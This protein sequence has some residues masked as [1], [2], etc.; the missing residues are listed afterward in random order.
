MGEFTVLYD[1]MLMYIPYNTTHL[2][3]HHLAVYDIYV[4]VHVIQLDSLFSSNMYIYIYTYIQ[5][6]YL[7]NQD[8]IRARI[9]GVKY[10]AK[11]K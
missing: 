11:A 8:D 7:G 10:Q 4:L 9:Q 6:R 1:N 2:I 5:G 3:H